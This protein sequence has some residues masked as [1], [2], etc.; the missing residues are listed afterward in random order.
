MAEK[1]G[2]EKAEI[3]FDAKITDINIYSQQNTLKIRFGGEQMKNKGLRFKITLIIISILLVQ[4]IIIFI[5]DK[6]EFDN[7][8]EFSIKNI[9][10][11][12]YN[13]L[14]NSIKEY[15]KIGDIYL[16]G[17][18]ANKEI[19]D[20]FKEK[21]RDKLIKLTKENY[22]I[23]KKEGKVEQIQFHE[24]SAISF[25]RLHKIEKYGDDLSEFR[26]TVVEA[27]RQKVQ[28]VGIEV[29]VGDLGVRVVRPI[30]DTEGNHLGSVE[31]G[32][33][34]DNKFIKKI[35]D[36]ASEELKEGGLDIS[37]VSKNLKGDLMLVGSSYEK[38]LEKNAG[39]IINELGKTGR[40]IEVKEGYVIS[41]T[42]L[43]DF[44]NNSI[45]FI[46]IKFSIS[47]ILK[48]QK[49]NFAKT[50]VIQFLTLI[51]IVGAISF[52]VDKLII[53]HIKKLSDISKDLADGEGDLTIRLNEKSKDE[54]GTMSHNMNNFLN[55]ISNIVSIIKKESNI[56]N[57]D[58]EEISH[59]MDTITNRA[60]KQIEIKDELYNGMKNIKEKMNVI[61]DNV[62]NQ[63]GATEE[64]SSS[65]IEISG[66]FEQI[67]KNAENTMVLSSDAYNSAEEGYKLVEN[68][69]DRIKDLENNAKKIDEK[70]KNLSQISEQT[71]LL[72]LNAAIEAARAGDA[73]KGFAVVA[74]EVRKLADSS[75]EF[76]ES[77]YNL[78]EEMKKSVIKSTNVSESTKQKI[79]EIK[80]KVEISN[81][82]IMSVSQ[83]IEELST[84]MNEIESGV[85]NISRSSS[86]IEEKA[87][88]Q[89]EIIDKNEKVL[90]ELG[91]IIEQ[92]TSS[93]EET[94]ASS[95]ELVAVA[96]GL[97]KMA[98]KF[99]TDDNSKGIQKL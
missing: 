66:S 32:G 94:S 64:I 95:V 8:L 70:L 72:A 31:Y 56:I 22:D 99:K 42:E 40:K 61:L 57:V 2:S 65:V 73:G 93:T 91:E 7:N 62:R 80:G 76:T 63:A 20:A 69:I 58:S 98:N 55:N 83:A 59:Q 33:N 75:K 68:T 49:E 11:Y 96:E 34:L 19:T 16:T 6:K 46:K 21:D 13:S 43:K 53:K 10:N 87:M 74:D 82:E 71:N 30:F 5:K 25:L 39:L 4:F 54:I 45:G 44:S 47:E 41:Y 79:K 37:I 85:Q 52:L 35:I 12:K 90:I 78:N 15:E 92:N 51:F 23:L 17:L 88:E 81:K 38:E 26:K 89:T 36:E 14:R 84:A 3:L 48:N 24:I 67:A 77:I 9:L 18:M 29:G 28:I 86:E 50:V 97:K 1:E 27:N 60:V